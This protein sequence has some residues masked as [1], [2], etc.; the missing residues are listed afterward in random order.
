[1]RI[2]VEAELREADAA[3]RDTTEVW[4]VYSRAI[5][6]LRFVRNDGTNGIHNSEYAAAI[7]DTVEKDFKQALVQ[8]DSV[9]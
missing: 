2:E 3:K 4:N 8:L 9:W 1:M 5:R 6:N 7:L